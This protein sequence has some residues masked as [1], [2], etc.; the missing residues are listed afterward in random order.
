MDLIT[1]TFVKLDV[2]VLF[3]FSLKI[4]EPDGHGHLYVYMCVFLV[5]IIKVY[6]EETSF[7][8][9]HYKIQK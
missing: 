1:T 8:K 9:H 3:N 5:T 2:H 7:Y 4:L 6:V